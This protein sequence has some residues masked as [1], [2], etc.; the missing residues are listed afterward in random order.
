[1]VHAGD[2]L[3]DGYRAALDF[4]GSGARPTAVV[5]YND[6][7]ALGVMRA[8]HETGLRVPDDVSVMVFDDLQILHY[9]PTPLSTVH[10]PKREMGE[11]ATSL[12]QQIESNGDARPE[13]VTLPVEIKVRASTAP[14]AAP[15]P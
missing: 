1:M 13:R 9:L 3:D 12:L 6:L 7:V 10:V 11:R 4:F 8:L 2:S 15:S 5:C 14:L